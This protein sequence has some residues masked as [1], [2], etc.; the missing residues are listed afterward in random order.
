MMYIFCHKNVTDFSRMNMTPDLMTA[1]HSV[2]K[3]K[4]VLHKKT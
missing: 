3:L 2:L 4:D 1:M